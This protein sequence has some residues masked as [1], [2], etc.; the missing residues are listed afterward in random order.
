MLRGF[1]NPWKPLWLLS[2]SLNKHKR[3]KPCGTLPPPTR[4]QLPDNETAQWRETGGAIGAEVGWFLGS[5]TWDSAAPGRVGRADNKWKSLNTLE[6]A[7]GKEQRP[8]PRSRW[9]VHLDINVDDCHIYPWSFSLRHNC[10]WSLLSP[11]LDSTQLSSFLIICGELWPQLRYNMLPF[12]STKGEL[13]PQL[14]Y[15]MLASF[16]TKGEL[17]PQ[18]H[19]NMLAFCFT[20]A[21]LWPRLRYNMLAFCFTK[22]EL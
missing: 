12:C 13:W 11:W 3:H 17:W 22:A 20:N 6:T 8:L 5:K 10:F 14:R 16:S 18:L 4:Q 15:N 2:S 21:E 9:L 7:N 19:Y 1:L